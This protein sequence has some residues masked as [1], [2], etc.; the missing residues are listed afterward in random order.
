MYVWITS[1]DTPASAIFRI[2]P[3]PGESTPGATELVGPACPADALA[4]A[5]GAALFPWA[6]ASLPEQTSTASSVEKR[7]EGMGQRDFIGSTEFPVSNSS[8]PAK[9]A[10][11]VSCSIA[12]FPSFFKQGGFSVVGRFGFA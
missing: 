8:T 11:S 3:T 2:S 5:V 7:R 10:A 6:G 1:V 9:P 12:L 4:A